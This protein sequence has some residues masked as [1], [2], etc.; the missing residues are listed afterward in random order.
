MQYNIHKHLPQTSTKI[1][2]PLKR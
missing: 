1:M 2:I